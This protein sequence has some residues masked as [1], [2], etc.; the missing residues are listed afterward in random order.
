VK[1]EFPFH[2]KFAHWNE[3]LDNAAPLSSPPSLTDSNSSSEG[4]PQ[5]PEPDSPEED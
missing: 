4:L 1:Q 3:V 2:Y 5:L